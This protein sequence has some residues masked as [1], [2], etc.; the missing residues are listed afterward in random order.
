MVDPGGRDGVEMVDP[1]GYGVEMVAWDAV[2]G[3]WRLAGF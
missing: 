2:G 3:C 1:G